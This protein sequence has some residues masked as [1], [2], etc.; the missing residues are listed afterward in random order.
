MVTFA[1]EPEYVDELYD[2]IVTRW[3][4]NLAKLYEAVGDRLHVLQFCDDLGTQ[5]APFL[6]T[7]M[8]RERVMPA[9]R[10]G[11]EWIHAHTPWKVLMHSDGAIFPLIPS[12]IEMGVNA[13]NPIQTTAVGMDL[14]RIK[15][16]FGA[17]LTLWGASGDSQNTL[18]FGTPDDVRAEVRK[19]L[20][21]LLPLSGGLIFS[22]VHNIQAT[23]PPENIVALFDS[24][25]DFP[26]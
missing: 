24:A 26:S 2:K 9:Y 23:V 15:E 8:F 25:L 1:S 10:R 4:E 5:S 17:R 14:V 7:T 22:A 16:E 12:L 19:H 18:T 13:L 21:I 11:I 3:I 6:S 20:E